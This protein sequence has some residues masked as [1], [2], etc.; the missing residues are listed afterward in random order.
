[1]FGPVRA[2]PHVT[3]EDGCRVIRTPLA[4]TGRL[5]DGSL[6][7]CVPRAETLRWDALASPGRGRAAFV[8]T[9]TKARRG[10]AADNGKNVSIF[11]T[12]RLSHTS[13]HSGSDT[14]QMFTHTAATGADTPCLLPF[15]HP[16]LRAGAS[17]PGFC[18]L[19]HCWGEAGKIC[20][21]WWNEPARLVWDLVKRLI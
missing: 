13:P 14:K 9:Q 1:M 15:C 8:C 20:R 6:F 19:F 2:C 11:D 17:P 16:W 7:T 10:V 12:D 3:D 4:H 18:H 21:N 5:L